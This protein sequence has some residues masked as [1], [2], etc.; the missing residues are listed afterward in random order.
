MTLS[1]QILSVIIVSFKSDKVIFNCIDS[2]PDSIDIVVVDNSNN[3][4]FKDNIEKKYKNVKCILSPKN[5]G[6]GAGNNLGLKYIN[7]NYAF[8]LNPDLILHK[9]AINEIIKELTINDSFGII[10]PLS[11]NLDYPNYNIKEQVLKKKNQTKPFSVKSVDGYAMVLNLKKIKKILDVKNYNY[12]DENF[13]MYLENDDLC[14][15]L[16]EKDL[17]VFIIPKSK[18]KHFGAKAVDPKYK[19]EV[20]LSRNWHWMWSKFYYNKKHY[21]YLIAL[22]DGLP[23]FGSAIIKYLIYSLLKNRFKK[24]IYLHRI[25]GFLSALLGKKSFYRPKIY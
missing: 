4:L 2:I 7:T 5:L 18:V 15:R 3:K 12:F 22:K 1:K 16:V 21:G 20:E 10:A 23:S 11:D 19:Y 17:E 25:Q 13:F 9:D 24:K 6:M 14:K 8:I